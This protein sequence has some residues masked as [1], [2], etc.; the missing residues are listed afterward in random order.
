VRARRQHRRRS[1]LG[2]KSGPS[3]A[4]CG[5]CSWIEL[6]PM[7]ESIPRKRGAISGNKHNLAF[8]ASRTTCTQCDAWHRLETVRLATAREA[9]IRHQ[10][11]GLCL[12]SLTLVPHWTSLSS[13]WAVLALSVR[14][15]INILDG[16]ALPSVEAER[17]G[18]PC[19]GVISTRSVRSICAVARDPV[20]VRPRDSWSLT[21]ARG[22][23]R[24][25]RRRAI[26]CA[27]AQRI[28]QVLCAMRLCSCFVK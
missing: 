26:W 8:S 28:S 11:R 21:T 1:H 16:R 5:C 7:N 13:R 14:S 23:I 15:A 6:A 10:K 25:Q 3:R 20:R 2:K 9:G 22:G 18:S 19:F 27:G 17:R 12:T 4:L 24:C